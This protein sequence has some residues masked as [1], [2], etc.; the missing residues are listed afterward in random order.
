[1][2][3]A[4]KKRLVSRF[5]ILLLIPLVF[6]GCGGGGGDSAP[7]Y[8]PL[9]VMIGILG[10]TPVPTEVATSNVDLSGEAYCDNCPAPVTGCAHL[11]TYY[12]SDSPINVTWANHTSG[13]TGNTQHGVYA[14]C[15]WALGYFTYYRHLWFSSVP[16]VTG[17]NVVEIKAS[18]TDGRSASQSVTVKRFPVTGLYGPR[19]IAVNAINEM[20][21]ASVSNAAIVVYSRTDSG[22][23]T[24]IRIISGPATGLDY[25]QS[26]ALDLSGNLLVQN[27][28]SVT[29]YPTWVAGDTAPIRTIAGASTAMVS[30]SGVTVDT[31]NGEIFVSNNNSSD[32]SITVY[33]LMASG[34]VVPLRTIKGALTGLVN[35]VE[36]GVDAVHNAIFVLDQQMGAIA[37]FDRNASGNVAPIRTISG[38]ATGL[39]YPSG[40]AVDA[41]N[42]E[43]F[44]TNSG[45]SSVTVYAQSASGD[46]APIRTISGSTTGLSNPSHIT[47]DAANNEIF[48][49]QG[50]ASVLVY[51]RT[52]TGDV[53][54][55][56]TITNPT[57]GL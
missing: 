10:G 49:T 17:D 9:W 53:A 7:P 25:P 35:P 47:V 50:N 39:S 16:L 13:A 40:I 42:N 31:N 29:V 2:E 24:P 5:P 19:G 48:V 27:R 32:S 45:N 30:P 51:A 57:Q 28:S 23:A 26:I 41:A 15:G 22:N 18:D 52:A 12:W 1:M 46:V 56:R 33:P 55:I 36:V 14:T 6:V 4:M 8:N 21:V 34:D 43:V 3:G 44:V 54:P 38:A 11:G 37:V 20:F